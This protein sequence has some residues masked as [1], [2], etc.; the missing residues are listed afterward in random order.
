MKLTCPTCGNKIVKNYCGNCGEK[1]LNHHDFSLLHFVEETF[2]GF[3][4]FD[5]K[6]FRT[7]RVLLFQPGQLS[8]DFCQGRRVPYLRPFAMFIICNILFFLAVGK[9][10]VFSQPLSSFYQYSPYIYFQTRETIEAVA[11]TGPQQEM[12][13]AKFNELMGSN[14]KAF[15]AI[16]I[17]FIA[18]GAMLVNYSKRKYVSEHLVFSTHFFTFIVVFYTFYII[19]VAQP[20]QRLN[21]F[22]FNETFDL[23]S[24]L[25]AICVIATYY[26]LASRR[27]YKIG[28]GRAV[29]ASVVVA[30][31]FMVTLMSYRILL[32]FKIMNTLS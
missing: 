17:P 19:L 10:N 15:L 28:R 24:T 4:H 29:L 6:F 30:I 9:A 27:F 11:K 13:A 16:F 25:V 22:G 7:A 18:V 20:F 31:V 5:N 32:F 12:L 8:V 3:T 1:K 26:G 21:N 14:S 2:E 23:F